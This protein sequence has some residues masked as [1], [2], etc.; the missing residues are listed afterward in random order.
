MLPVAGASAARAAGSARAGSARG[1][2]ALAGRA[3]VTDRRDLQEHL[4][5]I[6]QLGHALGRVLLELRVLRVLRDE[7][8]LEQLSRVVTDLAEEEAQLELVALLL[9]EVLQLRLVHGH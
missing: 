7:L 5:M 9:L 6:A 8:V 2:D 3:R 4:R 1:R